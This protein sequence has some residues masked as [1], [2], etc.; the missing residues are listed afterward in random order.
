M[1]TNAFDA[2]EKQLP[3]MAGKNIHT[4]MKNARLLKK[5]IIKP[6]V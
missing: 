2:K 4:I 1:L 3:I 6:I 5:K